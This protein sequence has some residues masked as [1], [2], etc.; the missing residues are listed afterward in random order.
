[1]K[2]DKNYKKF[3][4]ILFFFPTLLFA[5]NAI[6]GTGFSSGWDNGSCNDN[7]NFKYLG[8]SGFGGTYITTTA[9]SGTGNRYFR[10]GVDWSSSKYSVSGAGSAGQDNSV[11]PNTAYTVNGTCDNTGTMFYNVA[12]TSYNY[13]FKTSAAGTAV[14]GNKFVFFEI[15]GA[16]RTITT[17]NRDITSVSSSQSPL[18]TANLD[19]NLSTG[20]SVYLR[21]STDNFTTSSIQ[22]MTGSGTTFTA[23]IPTLAPGLT[24]RYYV[25][26]SGNNL[27]ISHADADLFTINGNTNGGA[28]YSYTVSAAYQSRQMGL[29]SDFNTWQ[30][31]NGTSWVNA[32]SGQ[33]PSSADGVVTIQNGH[34]VTISTSVTA[35]QV[36]VSSG[37][38]LDLNGAVTLTINDG[39]GTDLDVFGTFIQTTSTLT[40]NGQIVVENGGLLRQAKVG[41]AIPTSTWISGSTCEV[42]GWVATMGGG[43]DQAF[44]NFTYNC[45]GQTVSFLAL[46]PASMSV[47]GLL[48]VLSTGT[49]T[50]AL[51]LGND[52]IA[53]SL[54]VGSFE[55]SGTSK[56]YVAG[57]SST[58]NMSLTITN[59]FNQSGGFFEINRTNTN[60]GTCSVGTT[61][62]QSG[63]TTRVMNNSGTGAVLGTL[64][65]SGNTI[66]SGGTL[67]LSAA[68]VTNGGR[69]FLRGDLTVSSGTLLYTQ[70]LTGSSAS[71]GIYFDGN[72]NQTFTY[73]GGTI[74]TDTGG[75]GRRFFYKTSSGPTALNEIYNAVTAQNTIY[76]SEGTPASGYAYWPSTGT[77]LKTVTINNPA[78]VT[79]Q[80]TKSV[81]TTLFLK[82]GIF[83]LNGQSF[84]M[85]NGSTIDRTGGTISA[86]PAGTSYNVLYSPHT[87][88]L[89]TDLELPNTTTVLN[90]LTINN[91]NTITLQSNKTVNGNLSITTGVF[92]IVDKTIN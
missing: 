53:R 23:T 81:G 77:L 18:I 90:K 30:R 86:T 72:G 4:F 25:F 13:V 82:N 68:G 31:H 62:T 40:N 91:G 88:G 10:F 54:T 69:L 92:D 76:G 64:T 67:D 50:A 11:V 22:Q 32:T 52:S 79:L 33:V 63:G 34:T 9:A 80:S 35:D 20:Q 3:F 58:A 45:T 27:T 49:G 83:N 78:G 59:S 85:T 14:G 38:T 1:M 12:S 46:E 15:Q 65:I 89:T 6:V 24:V 60:T 87:A 17:V 71:S 57:A 21:Y 55:I 26:T 61:F 41:T 29:W 44:S 39:V 36:V 74:S 37:G 56:F 5:Q 43:I 75:V 7:S 42:T 8:S 51:S 66:I 28:N 84:T 73:S 70:A 16:V 47:S 48:K 19:G 2:T